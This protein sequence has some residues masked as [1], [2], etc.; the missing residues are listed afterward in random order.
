VEQAAALALELGGR[1]G[2]VV[3]LELEAGLRHGDVGRPLGASEAGLGGRGG[4][5]GRGACSRRSSR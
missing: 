5:T 4:A 2:D 1:G 3:D